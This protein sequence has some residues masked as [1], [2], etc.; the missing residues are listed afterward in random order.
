MAQGC[1]GIAAVPPGQD[2]GGAGGDTIGRIGG[3]AA[4]TGQFSAGVLAPPFGQAPVAAGSSGLPAVSARL[5]F[6][7][8]WAG[9]CFNCQAGLQVT[10]KR[11]ADGRD[12]CTVSPYEPAR[13]VRSP[14][15]SRSR[16]ATPVLSPL[17]DGAGQSAPVDD[18]LLQEASA[19]ARV[20]GSSALPD[21]QDTRLL[22]FFGGQSF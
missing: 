16:S 6:V 4:V 8:A 5:V 21:G 3:I 11:W 12:K 14:S 15:R 9:Q 17:G 18:T 22:E 10:V 1:E 2:G 13:L 7:K 20:E 19:E